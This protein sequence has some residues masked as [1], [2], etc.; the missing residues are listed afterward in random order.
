MRRGGK[1]LADGVLDQLADNPDAEQLPKLPY[2]AAVIAET[3]RIH[4][5][6]SIVVRQLKRSVT[7][8]QTERAPGDV[9]GVALPTLHADPQVWPNPGPVRPRALRGTQTLSDGV[10]T[11]RTRAPPQLGIVVRRPRVGDRAGNHPDQRRTA[12]PGSKAASQTAE[13]DPAGRGRRPQP[14]D[15]SRS[16]AQTRRSQAAAGLRRQTSNPSTSR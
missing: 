15:H 1:P 10:L 11:V 16:R 6:V 4:P 3:L 8:W 2:L 14:A 9:I 13:V 7:T 5:T 12:H